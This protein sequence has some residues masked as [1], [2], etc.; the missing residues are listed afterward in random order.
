MWVE[1]GVRRLRL[2]VQVRNPA[3]PL[4]LWRRRGREDEM[5][6]V[7]RMGGGLQEK[8]GAARRRSRWR[9]KGGVMC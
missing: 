9:R 7:T 5:S 8:G 1:G 2:V 3:Y 6:L 4:G